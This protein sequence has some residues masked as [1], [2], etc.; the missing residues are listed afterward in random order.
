MQ[1]G[2][3]LF[4]E[5]RLHD[6]E[7]ARGIL[8][9]RLAMRGAPLLHLGGVPAAGPSGGFVS[10]RSSLRL[11]TRLLQHD[12]AVRG[13]DLGFAWPTLRQ[14]HRIVHGR[15]LLWRPPIHLPASDSRWAAVHRRRPRI[16]VRRLRS[17]QRRSVYFIGFER[18]QVTTAAVP[19]ARL[20]RA[21]IR[22]RSPSSARRV[23]AYALVLR[24]RSPR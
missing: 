11:P 1:A 13:R 12:D 14:H 16:D 24:G 2:T 9:Q 20:G 21:R 18:V 23:A 8:R 6:A 3:V 5:R 7:R 19:R 10:Q 17:M 4:D 15:K 22:A